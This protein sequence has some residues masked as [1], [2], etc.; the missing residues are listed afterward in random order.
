M[1]RK[2]EFTTCFGVLKVLL[3]EEGQ[4]WQLLA[5]G[6]SQKTV[7]QL[8]ILQWEAGDGATGRACFEDRAI[9]AVSQNRQEFLCQ[10]GLG[11]MAQRAVTGKPNQAP[12]GGGGILKSD[13]LPWRP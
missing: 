1:H 13:A 6:G 9:E 12:G 4:V 2:Q 10:D 3:V 7:L 8:A 5:Q 11:K